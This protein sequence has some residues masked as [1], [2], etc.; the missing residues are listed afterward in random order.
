MIFIMMYG[1][2]ATGKTTTARKLFESLSRDYRCLMLST[3]SYR[4]KYNLF[5]LYSEGQRNS[6]YNYL[7]QDIFRLQHDSKY[8]VI[9]IDGNYNKY[10][11]RKRLYDAVAGYD[12][13]IIK[14][15]VTS[16]SIIQERLED[17]QKNIHISENKAS[18][19]DL[20]EL[21][22]ADG[23]EIDESC[24]FTSKNIYLVKYNTEAGVLSVWDNKVI[25]EKKIKSY[26]FDALIDNVNKRKKPM[27][28]AIIFD[29]GGVI[30]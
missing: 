13:Y 14:C 12:L 20:H 17:R 2:P 10:L 23:D 28:K 3:L 9:I 7:I 27:I 6:V 26:I 1:Y 30:Q 19:A 5:D 25:A 11:R 18:T 4:K 15:F 24:E 8:D 21:I 29:I 22:K 16:T